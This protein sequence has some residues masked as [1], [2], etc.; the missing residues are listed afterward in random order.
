M[1][2]S[3]IVGL[4]GGIGS[5]KSTVAHV[6]SMLGIPVWDA[7]LA[8][9]L[10]YSENRELQRWVVKRFGKQCGIWADENL[11]EINRK[12]LASL[13]FKD[14]EALKALNKKVHPL[15]RDSFRQWHDRND[16]F[17]SSPYVIRES[18]ILFESNS[19]L[20]CDQIISVVAKEP[21]RIQRVT[22]RDHLKVADVQ[23]RISKQLKD[24]ERV[25]KSDFVIHNDM[26]SPL[27]QQVIDI[28]CSLSNLHL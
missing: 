2:K 14:R 16:D 3:L 27:L 4:T 1:T 20:D 13:V 15:V 18:A 12:A 25:G 17:Q 5:E 8:G 9:R 11:L 26:N 24:V 7:D 22:R 21:L 23:A 6:F 28:H 10:L 19:H